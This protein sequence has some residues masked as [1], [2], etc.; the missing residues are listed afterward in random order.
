VLESL[1]EERQVV[2]FTHDSRLP[3]AVS[4]LEIDADVLE[5]V[6]AERSVVT[7]RPASDPIVRYLDDAYA[8]AKSDQ[9]PVHV[10]APVVAELCRSAMEAAF[11]RIVWRTRLAKGVRHADIEAALDAAKRTTVLAALAFFDDP[12]RG[13]DVMGRIN[14]YG[15]R[16]GDAFRACVQGVHAAAMADPAGI[17]GDVRDFIEALG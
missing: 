11:A 10:Q 17:V 16:F 14:R 5:V 3:D 2:V 6:R 15:R 12:G 8:V 1:A 4:R 13:G 7:I 9:M